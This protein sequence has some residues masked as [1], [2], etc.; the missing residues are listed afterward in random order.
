MI[1]ETLVISLLIMTLSLSAQGPYAPPAG[2]TGT[3]AI[4]KDSTIFAYWA[5]GSTIDRGPQDLSNISLG[6]SNVGTSASAIGKSGLN[7]IVSLGDGGSATL[8]FDA[9]IINGLGADF[10]I[11]ENSFSD[12]FL[13]LA[14]V[15]VSSDGINFYRF[16]AISLTDTSV[17]TL[18]FGSTDATNIYNLA[19]KYRG[20]YGTPFDLDELD[21]IIGLDVNSITHIKIIDVVGS[22]NP[23]YA[24]YDSQNRAVNDPWPTPFGSSGFDLDAIGVINSSA[25]EI[26]EIANGNSVNLFPNPI[27][28][29][30]N[31]QMEQKKGCKF[32]ILTYS[33]KVI[34]SGSFNDNRHQINLSCLNSGVY[35]LQIASEQSIITKKI[36]K[37]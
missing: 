20:Q 11:F 3:T 16:G 35:F 25:T 21:G 15:E 30:L 28:S 33:G 24:T 9:P 14:F 10:A 37:Y 36:I 26:T 19:G 4:N 22:I 6:N 5:T 12:S 17:Q 29:V 18:G 32:T 7:G 34:D 27:K 23:L 2:Q 13:E 8:T 31:I 1:K